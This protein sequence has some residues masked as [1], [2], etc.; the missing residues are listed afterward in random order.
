VITVFVSSVRAIINPEF[1]MN[2]SISALQAVEYT[3]KILFNGIL[4]EAGREAYNKI[5][6]QKGQV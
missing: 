6:S 1:I 2:N 5:V 4:T 3:F